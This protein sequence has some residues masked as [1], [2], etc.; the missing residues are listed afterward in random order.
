[1]LLKKHK[2]KDHIEV[3]GGLYFL[4]TNQY[5][6]APGDQYGGQDYIFKNK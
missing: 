5:R 6:C 4:K 3:A 2:H 1:M